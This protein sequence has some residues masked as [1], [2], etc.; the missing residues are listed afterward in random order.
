VCI[1]LKGILGPRRNK[2]APQIE[3]NQNWIMGGLRI[4]IDKGMAVW[5]DMQVKTILG[6]V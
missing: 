4:E 6:E 5:E 2:L 1:N 3:G